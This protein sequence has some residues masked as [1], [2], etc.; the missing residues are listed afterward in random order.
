MCLFSFHR[1]RGAT[2]IEDYSP[3]KEEK[4]CRCGLI[5]A[6]PEWWNDKYLTR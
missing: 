4:A 1:E 5:S 3:V 2:H 6:W